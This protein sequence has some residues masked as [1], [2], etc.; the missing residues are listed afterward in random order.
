MCVTYECEFMFL[1][2]KAGPVILVAFIAYHTTL[3]SCNPT[4]WINI[5]ICYSDEHSYI[6]WNEIKFHHRTEWMWGTFLDRALHEDTNSQY[7]VLLHNLYC[8]IWEPQLLYTDTNEAVL[9]HFVIMMFSVQVKP[10]VFME[11]SLIWHQFHPVL[12]NLASVFCIF[13]YCLEWNL[14][15]KTVSHTCN[16]FS[17]FELAH[18]KTFISVYNDISY[19][20]RI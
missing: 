14:L 16:L 15:F 5:K 10:V 8:T 12:L 2:K 1:E 17:C 18:Q 20:N 19:R 13:S 7:S 9:L 11:I 6:H 3:T 4:S